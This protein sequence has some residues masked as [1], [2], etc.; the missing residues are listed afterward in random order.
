M[1]EKIE[2]QLRSTVPYR[3][4][5]LSFMNPNQ[6]IND[7]KT[8]FPV[9]DNQALSV[10]H[11]IAYAGIKK[12][13]QALAG[14]APWTE[15]QTGKQRVP[16]LIPSRGTGLGCGPGPQRRHMRGNHTLRFLSLSFSLP[17]LSL[18]MNK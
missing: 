15:H 6:H 1:E 13:Q 8:Y 7:M 18:K 9:G 14:V 2:T 11:N 3:Q 5:T 17:P 12:K 16:S 10:T 4:F